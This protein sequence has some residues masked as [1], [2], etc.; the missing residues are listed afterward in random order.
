MPS[1]PFPGL[2]RR[3]RRAGRTAATPRRP[4]RAPG[5]WR[6]TGLGA[7]TLAL[8]VPVFTAL[9][10]AAAVAQA[11][12]PAYSADAVYRTPDGSE[13]T[14]RVVKSGP[15]MRLEYAEN[16]RQ[17]IQ[18]IRRAEGTMY[19]LDPGTLSYFRVQG[20]ADPNAGM[21]AYAPPCDQNAPGATCRFLGN[22]VTSGITTEVWEI[23]QP[24]DPAQVSRILWDGARQR[25]LRQEYPDGTV[26]ALAFKAMVVIE[27]RNVEHWTI[28][29]TAPGQAPVTGAWYYDPE[30]RVELREELPSGEIRSLRNIAV[31]PV[32]PAAFAVPSGWSEIAPPGPGTGAAAVPT[33]P[34]AN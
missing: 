18:I 23:G 3:R 24:G 34:S 11:I 30:L 5:A 12:I 14:G 8:L 19:V 15:D 28:T 22:E 26:M 32:D 21:A 16:G 31:G 6:R 4:D 17:V 2:I 9:T 25:A 20:A 27:G 7:G 13:S 10:P 33:P 29:V 1:I